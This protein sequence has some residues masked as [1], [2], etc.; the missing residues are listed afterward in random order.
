MT[1]HLTDSL[2]I[3]GALFLWN[4]A[5]TVPSERNAE[6]V[7]CASWWCVYF[8]IL[9]D[10]VKI[11][12]AQT[13][14]TDLKRVFNVIIEW[15]CH[16]SNKTIGTHTTAV[17]S[18]LGLYIYSFIGWKCG[19]ETQFGFSVLVYDLRLFMIVKTKGITAKSSN[20]FHNAPVF[21]SPTKWWYFTTEST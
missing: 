12:S 5:N 2:S 8:N 20:Y 11:K 18:L 6:H 7:L 10:I 9:V 14:K 4:H 21:C 15:A 13:A 1:R 19:N 17:E 3:V 16:G